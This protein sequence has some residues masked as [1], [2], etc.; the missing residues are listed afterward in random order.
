MIVKLKEMST[1][2]D[3]LFSLISRDLRAP[4]NSLLG[5]AEILGTEF[6]SLT[7][8]DIKEYLSV[9]NDSSKTLYEM[10]NNLLRY[11]KIQLNKYDYVPQ[12]ILRNEIIGGAIE[13]LK[14]RMNKK[15]ILV[16]MELIKDY[17]IV[18]DEEMMTIVF[19]NLIS[20]AIK[21]SN[22]GSV[23]KI[24]AEEV[25]TIDSDAL[26]VQVSVTDEGIGISEK[27]QHLINSDEVFSTPGTVK[28]PGSG[29][30]LLL[31]KNYILLNKG[32]FEI[33]SSE[34]EGTTIIVTLPCLKTG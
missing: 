5:F 21:F 22:K 13:S 31:S 20:N 33:I 16:K 18:A 15:S 9:I 25:K 26:T 30:G 34:G 17:S 23:V 4:F 32:K 2:K 27:N 6:E 7:H 3:R 11:S 24:F 14:Y 12:K 19:E 1:S 28:E 29:L 8:R 10:T